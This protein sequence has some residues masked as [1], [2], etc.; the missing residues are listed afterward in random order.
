MNFLTRNQPLV[1]SFG[2][3]WYPHPTRV[4]VLDL[5]LVLAF[6]WIYSRPSDDVC[7][8]GGDVLVNYEGVCSD[9]VTLKM[10]CRLSLS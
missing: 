8:V 9:L 4:Q 3:Q 1:G 2:G 5:T 10:M 7:L 6:S